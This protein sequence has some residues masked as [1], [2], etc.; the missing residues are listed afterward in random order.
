MKKLVPIFIAA[1]L[2]SC[3]T[4][5]KTDYDKIL[6]KSNEDFSVVEQADTLDASNNRITIYSY[7]S[8]G[9]SKLEV[10]T[11]KHNLYYNETE[12]YRND[13]LILI[14]KVT[15]RS[16]IVYERQRE[17]SEPVG[18]IIERISYFRNKK[19]GI[20]K[21][22]RVKFYSGDIDDDLKKQNEE[23]QKIDFEIKEIGEKEYQHTQQMY[24]QFSKY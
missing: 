11:N 7:E 14:E 18:E 16:P 9:V 24:E 19:N 12:Y 13:S 6:E 4:H 8:D 21:S 17:K 23:L 5:W 1:F 3:Q 10:N 15:E 2:I 22:R 20:E